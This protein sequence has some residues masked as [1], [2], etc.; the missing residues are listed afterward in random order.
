M[1]KRLAALNHFM[2]RA[3]GKCLSFFQILRKASKFEWTPDCK[4]GFVWLKTYVSQPPLLFKP[5]PREIL[6][7]YL[8]VSTVAVSV[9]LV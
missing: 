9:V 8:M 3:T 2:S 7:L 5:Q 1:T 4:K 6:Y